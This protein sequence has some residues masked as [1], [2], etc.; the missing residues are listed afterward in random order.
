MKQLAVRTGC[1]VFHIGIGARDSACVQLLNVHSATVSFCCIECCRWATYNDQINVSIPSR[2]KQRIHVIPG[3]GVQITRIDRN[4]H[5]A[6]P[7]NSANKSTNEL[8]DMV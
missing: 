6:R 1:Q 3:S 7:M 5:K 2:M 4:V 8:S